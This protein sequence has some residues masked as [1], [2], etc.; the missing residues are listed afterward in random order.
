MTKTTIITLTEAR[1]AETDLLATMARAPNTPEGFA[2]YLSS[3]KALK[4]LR[5]GI[6]KH[7]KAELVGEQVLSDDEMLAALGV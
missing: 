3:E 5:R 1:N 6:K 4:S 2:I 7:F